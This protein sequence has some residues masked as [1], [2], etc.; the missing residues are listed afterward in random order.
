MKDQ[1]LA[2]QRKWRE[3]MIGFFWLVFDWT[4]VDIAT[5]LSIVRT[6]FP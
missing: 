5:R 6:L 3:S 4:K 1:L 2:G